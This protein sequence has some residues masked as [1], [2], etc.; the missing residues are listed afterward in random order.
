[1]AEVADADLQIF[2]VVGGRGGGGW[3][4]LTQKNFF[5][6]PSAGGGGVGG[7]PSI[8]KFPLT[9]LLTLVNHIVE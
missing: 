6:G 8:T 9:N 1:M 2:V 3:R 7:F 5:F 4:V